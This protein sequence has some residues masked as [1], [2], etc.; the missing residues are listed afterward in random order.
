MFSS[1]FC[2]ISKNTFFTEHLWETA[3]LLSFNNLWK[4]AAESNKLKSTLGFNTQNELLST[5][6][7][8]IFFWTPFLND[9]K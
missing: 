8:Q 9:I 4:A 2:E 3:S 6:V 5:K 7:T 1:E